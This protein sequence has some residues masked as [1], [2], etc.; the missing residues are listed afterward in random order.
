MDAWKSEIRDGM[1]IDW[2]MPIV[3][4]DGLVLRA[5]IFRP[6][7]EESFQSFF[8]TAHTARGLLFKK[9]INRMG[10]HGA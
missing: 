1:H 7:H 8:P 2:D 10:N 6:T 4:D 9:A 5:D 3:M